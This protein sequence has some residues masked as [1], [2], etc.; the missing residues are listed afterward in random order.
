MFANMANIP[1]LHDPRNPLAPLMEAELDVPKA[2]K[3]LSVA[4]PI[5]VISMRYDGERYALV[6]KVGCA[7]EPAEMFLSCSAVGNPLFDEWG[8]EL[9]RAVKTQAKHDIEDGLVMLG[10]VRSGRKILASPEEKS[11]ALLAFPSE[12]YFGLFMAIVM[13]IALAFIA[14]STIWSAR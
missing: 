1:P 3:R 9:E 2:L 6:Y 8:I 10:S 5:E 7:R 11:R 14:Y 13:G 12:R 4:L